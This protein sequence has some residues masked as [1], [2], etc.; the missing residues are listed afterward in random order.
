MIICSRNSSNT[1]R[2]DCIK[3]SINHVLPLLKNGFPPLDFPALDPF[4][5]NTTYIEYEQNILTSKL[6]VTNT[7][8]TGLSTAEVKSVRTKMNATHLYVLFD[9]HIPMVKLESDYSGQTKFNDL[10]VDSR[11]HAIVNCCKF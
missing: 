2:A 9:L 8:V 3:D 1:I 6:N 10:L 4:N 11:G 7:L 5:V